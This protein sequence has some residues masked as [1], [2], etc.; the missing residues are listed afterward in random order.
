VLSVPAVV[1]VTAITPTIV[2]FRA[3]VHVYQGVATP[4]GGD[5]PADAVI[6]Y[7]P[8]AEP[9]SYGETCTLPNSMH[10]I[11][12]AELNTFLRSQGAK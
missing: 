7:S 8:T 6:T 1:L 12:T 10:A 3:D 4:S 5:Y 11:C 9:G 2:G